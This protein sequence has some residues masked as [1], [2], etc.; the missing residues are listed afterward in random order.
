MF[1]NFFLARPFGYIVESVPRSVPDFSM[2]PLKAHAA[3]ERRWVGM[4]ASGARPRLRRRRC[5]AGTL[6]RTGPERISSARDARRPSRAPSAAPLPPVTRATL[7]V[8]AN[9]MHDAQVTCC[10]GL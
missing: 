7:K 10:S 3:L 4:A 1:P 5:G 2:G 8:C 6:L 9:V